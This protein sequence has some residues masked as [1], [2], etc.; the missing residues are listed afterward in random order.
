MTKKKIFCDIEKE[1]INFKII[2]YL[3]KEH[4][5]PHMGGELLI[6][7]FYLG[8]M[9][10]KLLKSPVIFDGRNL[11]NPSELEHL[12]FSYYGIGRGAKIHP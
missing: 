1:K 4:F 7:G 10:K 12:G 3:L 9:V 5:I 8:Y 2:L 6:K 11:Y